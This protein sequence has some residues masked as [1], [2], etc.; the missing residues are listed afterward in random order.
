MQLGPSQ[1]L[2]A[3][4]VAG[5]VAP[6]ALGVFALG[7]GEAAEAS[8]SLG[9]CREY[10][11]QAVY[12]SSTLVVA[13]VPT[14]RHDV[15]VGCLLRTGRHR[16][17]LVVRPNLR[18]S[19]VTHG[20]WIVWE[21]VQTTD[22]GQVASASIRG[23]NIRTNKRSPRV[24]TSAQLSGPVNG[25]PAQ[26]MGDDDNL[27]LVVGS[28]GYYAWVVSGPPADAGGPGVD[29]VYVADGHGGSV[30]VDLGPLDSVTRLAAHNTTV[31]WSNAG[32][33]RHIRLGPR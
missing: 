30:R 27:I 7:S 32:I 3:L 9:H 2:R 10:K 12:R 11:S 24:D 20:A 6:A 1:M 4:M 28:N 31:T 21:R 14:Q 16:A 29:A 26:T 8:A 18:V 5:A 19:F 13:I 25:P 23:V 17:F 33:H 15:Y 22:S